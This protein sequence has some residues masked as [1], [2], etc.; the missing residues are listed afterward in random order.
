[1]I[2]MLIINVLWW[3]KLHSMLQSLK[4][5]RLPRSRPTSDCGH[6]TY[7]AYT[8]KR[9]KRGTTKKIV[10]GGI[11]LAEKVRSEVL[12]GFPKGGMTKWGWSTNFPLLM[13]SRSSCLLASNDSL[14]YTC[15]S[16]SLLGS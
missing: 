15:H 16:T 13:I 10:S 12:D 11:S 4:I 14:A 2:A 1:M 6:E 8:H 3:I 7:F 5:A 9:A